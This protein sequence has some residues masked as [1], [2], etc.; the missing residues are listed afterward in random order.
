MSL[1]SKKGAC[2]NCIKFVLAKKLI[3]R[4]GLLRYMDAHGDKLDLGTDIT[5]HSSTYDL[6][7]HVPNETF[8][9]LVSKKTFVLLPYF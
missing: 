9:L 4:S 1:E 8:F 7:I 6:C 3:I 5:F 2:I